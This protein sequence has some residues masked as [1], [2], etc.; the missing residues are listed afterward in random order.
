[1]GRLLA[2]HLLTIKIQLLKNINVIEVNWFEFNYIFYKKTSKTF[3][4][5]HKQPPASFSVFFLNLVVGIKK[6][7]FFL[8]KF[9][10]R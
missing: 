10:Y 5:K 8:K 4:Q 2:I 6:E 1:M 3:H 7:T 9:K